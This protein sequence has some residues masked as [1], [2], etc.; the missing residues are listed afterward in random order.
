MKKI[1]LL[2]LV[3]IFNFSCEVGTSDD[4]EN[5]NDTSQI[6]YRQEM[7]NFVK[8]ISEYANDKDSDFIVITQN[9]IEL[10]TKDGEPDGELVTEYLNAIDGVG[11]EDLFYGYED[12]NKPTLKEVSDYLN[13]FLQRVKNGGKKVLVTDYCW[14]KSKIDDSYQ[15]NYSLGYISIATCRELNCIPKYPLKPYN[16]N[17]NNINSL[18][19]AQNF[20]Y[21]INPEKFDTKEEFIQTL[22]NTNYD[23]LIVDAFFNDELLSSDDVNRL[24][25]K[26]NGGKRLVISY[27]SIGEAEDYRYYWKDE[28]KN[29]PPKWL[30]EE[31]P[32]W[33]G[34]YKVKYWIKDWQKIIYGSNDSYLDKI[35]SAGFDGVYLD[36]ID[37][38]EYFENKE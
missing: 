1:L 38:F 35:L 33:E 2:F 13:S 32:D 19:D 8:G 20:L 24:K 27:M 31:N 26:A 4:S 6:D 23:I 14:D 30:D 25:T 7:R 16:E 11:Q 9:G 37:A 21:L 5:S 29:N 22:E 3:L 34:N 36:I 12:D 15:K 10:I 18:N 28:W 17:L